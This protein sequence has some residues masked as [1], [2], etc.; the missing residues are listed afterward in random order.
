[1]KKYYAL[2]VVVV[3]II[4]FVIAIITGIGGKD[5]EVTPVSG[6]SASV[7]GTQKPDMVPVHLY[8]AREDLSGLSAE[9]RYIPIEQASKSVSA[10][11]TLIVAELIKGPTP[12]SQLSATVPK[13]TDLIGSV[14]VDGHTA[15]VNLNQAFVNNHPGDKANEQLTIYSIVNSLTELKDIDTVAFRIED[16]VR[17][18]YMGNYRF[19]KPFPRTLSLV[20]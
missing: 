16:C 17:E 9:I 7:Q 4:A 18:E 5:D 14:E 15:I 10:L 20:K 8:F 11:A 3:V 12:T 1:M 6:I 19:D 2:G 13:D